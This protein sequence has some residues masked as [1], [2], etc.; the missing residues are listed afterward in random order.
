[1]STKKRFMQLYIIMKQISLEDT[2]NMAVT[3][4]LI[5]LEKC[6]FL[7][8][9]AENDRLLVIRKDDTIILFVYKGSGKNHIPF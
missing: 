5:I 4:N 3:V 6:L 1:M 8:D 2:E 9:S 7:L